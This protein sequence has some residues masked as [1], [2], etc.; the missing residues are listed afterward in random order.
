L[1][2]IFRTASGFCFGMVNLYFWILAGEGQTS[3]SDFCQE[4]VFQLWDN[5]PIFALI[6]EPLSSHFAFL[7]PPVTHFL[8]VVRKH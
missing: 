6:V 2:G 4:E 7:Q 3:F 8:A 1:K 5:C